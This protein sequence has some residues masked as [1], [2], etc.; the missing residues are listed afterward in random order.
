MEVDMAASAGMVATRDYVEAFL[1]EDAPLQSARTRAEEL[2]SSSV[3]P[4]GGALLRFLAK[5]VG[6]KAVVEIG[7]GTGVS[8]LWLLRGMRPDGVLTSVDP[9]VEHHRAAK[10]AFAEAGVASSRTRLIS[11]TALEVLPRLTDNAY[12]LVFCD[13]APTEYADYLTEAL[14]LLRPGGV[15][16]FDNML[17][18]DRVADASARDPE[19]VA[20]RDVG[21]TIREH[22]DLVPMLVGVSGGLLAATYQPAD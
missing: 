3:S 5:L 10:R 6:A 12:D 20:I 7:T 8:G 21:R 16:A 11:G 18:H 17:W 4:A 2:G 14:R 13:G 19:T 22:D 15:V 9:E 1:D